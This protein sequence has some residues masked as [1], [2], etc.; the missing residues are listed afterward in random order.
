[1]DKQ[2]K[3]VEDSV[4]HIYFSKRDSKHDD[5]TKSEFKDLQNT[6]ISNL[7][8]TINFENLYEKKQSLQL[9]KLLQ[10][11]N[12]IVT[13]LK[14]NCVYENYEWKYLGK[15]R[16][17]INGN[18]ARDIN[19]INYFLKND[20]FLAKSNINQI[21]LNNFLFQN[22]NNI[23]YWFL[24]SNVE[25]F[26]R[27]ELYYLFCMSFYYPDKVFNFNS[28]NTTQSNCNG[29]IVSDSNSSNVISEDF[30]FL[31]SYI[32]E[33]FVN[34][35]NYDF[36]L[37]KK[38]N[39]MLILP[40]FNLVCKYREIFHNSEYRLNQYQ[41][42]NLIFFLESLLLCLNK[43]ITSIAFTLKFET[44]DLKILKIILL[45]LVKFT[46]I[47]FTL[48][49]EK[50]E[51]FKELLKNEVID[52]IKEYF[53]TSNSIISFKIFILHDYSVAAE[54]Y[55]K[56]YCSLLLLMVTSKQSKLRKLNRRKNIIFTLKNF[57]NNSYSKKY[58]SQILEMENERKN[59]DDC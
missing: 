17:E 59:E 3:T 57:L 47:V 23:T 33:Y 37:K 34:V 14:L 21:Y 22:F 2:Q 30:N 20:I 51:I 31:Q 36:N 1:M 28:E 46:H 48:K 52:K 25:K 24:N 9:F 41:E 49:I 8:L 42:N 38:E 6:L 40:E 35:H 44:E 26:T 19:A 55:Y 39:F 53:I 13:R 15:S 12:I 5:N 56:N 7:F 4:I 54:Y 16:Y 43:K 10:E 58:F 29:S 11:N 27:I 18:T 50:I 32:S 45:K